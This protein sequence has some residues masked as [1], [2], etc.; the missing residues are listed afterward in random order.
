MQ[1]NYFQLDKVN[2]ITL[3]YE[4]DAG[5]IWKEAIPAREK[6]F[7]GI[8]YG[9]YPAVPAGWSEYEKEDKYDL[10]RRVQSSYFDNYSWYRVDEVNKKVYNKAHVDIRFSYKE[11]IG[12]NFESNEEAQ[13][14]VDDLIFTAAP[15]KKFT[16]IIK[17]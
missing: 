2:S 14:W 1:K 5:Y 3:T 16:V 11:G 7:M 12:Q 4:R 8:K 13:Q 17:K 6:Q 15:D 10:K 9:M